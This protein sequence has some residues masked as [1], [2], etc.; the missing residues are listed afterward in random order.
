MIEEEAS[1]CSAYSEADEQENDAE[2]EID[3]PSS[4]RIL[5]TH[6]LIR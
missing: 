2:D 3:L 6:R 4:S 1:S 5:P